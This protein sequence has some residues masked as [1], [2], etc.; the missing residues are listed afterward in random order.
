MG[1]SRSAKQ[2][3]QETKQT[4]GT[5]RLALQD[6]LESTNPERRAAALRT[7]VVFGRAVTNVLQNLRGVIPDFDSWYLPWKSQMEQDQL[8][9]FFYNLRTEILKRGTLPVSAGLHI[10]RFRY[11]EDLPPA[12]PN[13]KSFFMGDTLGG[14]GWEVELP[15]GSTER[16]YVAV[17]DEVAVTWLT[18]SG[19]PAEHLGR[20]IHDKS[21]QSLCTLYV[22][23]LEG[24]VSDAQRRFEE[25]RKQ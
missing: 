15:D 21:A 16:V 8:L 10:K 19:A 17:L 3:L 22:T 25:D 13:A 9:R 2:I 14:I 20:P 23:Y 7:L 12:P 6:L 11:P 24:L 18:F 5:V 1:V 4:L